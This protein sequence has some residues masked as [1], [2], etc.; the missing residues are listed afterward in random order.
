[1]KKAIGRLST[2]TARRRNISRFSTPVRLSS[3]ATITAMSIGV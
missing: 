1:M 3:E 2:W